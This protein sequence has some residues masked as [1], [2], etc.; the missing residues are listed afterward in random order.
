MI[1]RKRVLDEGEIDLR[2]FTTV[3]IMRILKCYDGYL[4]G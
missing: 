2:K 3:C 1:R 4:L